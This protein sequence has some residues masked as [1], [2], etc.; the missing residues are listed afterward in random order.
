MQANVAIS[1]NIMNIFLLK[2]EILNTCKD[3]YGR[4]KQNGTGPKL[5]E[6]T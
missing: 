6:K 3:S 1:I 4:R 2:N 5:F